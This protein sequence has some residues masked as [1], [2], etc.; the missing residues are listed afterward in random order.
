MGV[1]CTMIWYISANKNSR[2]WICLCYQVYR[3]KCVDGKSTDMGKVEIA[4]LVDHCI[5]W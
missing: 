5:T 3:V 2:N 1:T 4:S